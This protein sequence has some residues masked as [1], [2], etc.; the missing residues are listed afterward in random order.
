MTRLLLPNIVRA[1]A[2]RAFVGFRPRRAVAAVPMATPAPARNPEAMARLLA[3]LPDIGARFWAMSEDE[4]GDWLNAL[5]LDEFLEYVGLGA[6]GIAQALRP[7]LADTDSTTDCATDRPT[8]CDTPGTGEGC[9]EN[10]P[11]ADTKGRA[12]GR[13][14]APHGAHHGHDGGAR[15]TAP[16]G[17]A[18]AG[19]EAT[20]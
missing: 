19:D 15:A 1:P 17:T 10:M 5:P 14:R 6:Q 11:A 8:G 9:Q 7:Y 13:R 2:T 16:A 20:V 12:P 4:F 3:R 18:A